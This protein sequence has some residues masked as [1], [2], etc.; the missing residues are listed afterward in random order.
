MEKVA[1]LPVPDW[2]WAITSRPV[3]QIE[4]VHQCQNLYPE[5]FHN[6]ALIESFINLV[7]LLN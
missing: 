1:V 3:I 7:D 6:N 5:L 2:A 4:I